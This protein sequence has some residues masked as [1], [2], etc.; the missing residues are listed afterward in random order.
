MYLIKKAVQ[1]GKKIVGAD[2][3]E[4]SPGEDEWDANVGARALYRVINLMAMS[5]GLI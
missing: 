3:N 5:Q 1:S 2:L 4:V